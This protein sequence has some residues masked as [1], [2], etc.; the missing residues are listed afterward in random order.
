MYRFIYILSLSSRLCL[1][2]AAIKEDI[3]SE[4]KS[5]DLIRIADDLPSLLQ[6]ARAESTN[7]NYETAF[8]RWL[9]WSE[10][11]PEIEAFYLFILF[12]FIFILIYTQYPISITK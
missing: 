7:K 1:L 12:F 5:L 8:K 3:N 11:F 9:K 10:K 6:K 2:L 4:L